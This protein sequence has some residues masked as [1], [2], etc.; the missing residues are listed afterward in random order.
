MSVGLNADPQPP[1]TAEVILAAE[2]RLG[3]TFPE[4]YRRFLLSQDGLKGWF[5]EIYLELYPVQ[6]VVDYTEAHDHQ[7]RFPGLVFIGGDGASEA[8][9]YDFRK[10]EP[11]IVLVNLVSAGWH[12]A[13][14]QAPTFTAFMEQRARGEDFNWKDGYE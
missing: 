11:P 14:Y 5:A 1:A 2:G 3:V 4:D 12:E 6:S 8:V 9:G 13:L 10:A 7:D